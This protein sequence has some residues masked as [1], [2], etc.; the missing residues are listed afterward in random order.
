[1]VAN[2]KL[3]EIRSYLFIYMY[4]VRILFHISKLD[5]SYPALGIFKDKLVSTYNLPTTL[6]E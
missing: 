4:S 5:S 3:W 2:E 6:G 1:M